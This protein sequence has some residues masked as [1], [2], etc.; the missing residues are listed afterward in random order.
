MFGRWVVRGWGGWGRICGLGEG[1]AA[2]L[3]G[4][5]E[6][7]ALVGEARE[8]GG[9]T[10]ETKRGFSNDEWQRKKGQVKT[11][12]LPPYDFPGD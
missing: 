11:T 8:A 4:A 1:A 10:G 3:E 9:R 6:G 7:A 12:R 2:A 5:E